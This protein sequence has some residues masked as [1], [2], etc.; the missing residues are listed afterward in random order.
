MKFYKYWSKATEEVASVGQRWKA[1]RYGAS[2]VSLAD[3]KA[4]AHRLAQQ[5]AQSLRSGDVLDRYL[6]SDR[7]VREE[8]VEEFGDDSHPYAVITRNAYGSLVLNTSRVM[9]A[10]IDDPE[11]KP[12][13]S[14]PL[15]PLLG[16]LGGMFGAAG[17]A[18]EILGEEPPVDIPARIAGFVEESPGLGLRLYR[19]FAG[20]R[21]LVTSSE[22]QPLSEETRSLLEDLG[23]DPLYVKLCQVQECF[24]ARLTP[25]FWRCALDP[26]PVRF[27]WANA[28]QEQSMRQWEQ[29]YTRGIEAYSTC[30]FVE[31]FGS[32]ET[33]AQI[34]TIVELHDRM[35]C[36]VG[37]PLA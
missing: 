9:F 18:E 28:A 12:T 6:Y 32:P 7:P 27:P 21:C 14:N 5:T 35:C 25:K 26:P 31:A 1:K 2:N 13:D 20:F 24:R 17:L 37:K 11:P 10:D 30:E 29:T 36:H 19:T 4:N 8:I 15:K 3:A 16:L 33:E 22:F 34:S 23:S